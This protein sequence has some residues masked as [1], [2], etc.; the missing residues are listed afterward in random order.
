[1]V[2]LTLAGAASAMGGRLTGNGGDVVPSGYSIDSRTLRRGDLFFALVGPNH[3]GHRFAGAAADAGACALV[4]DR[5]MDLPVPVLQVADTTRGLQDLASHVRRRPDLK[6]VGITGSAGKTTAKEMTYAVVSGLSPAY[7]SQGNLNNLY[8]LPLSLL[9]MP[10]STHVAVLE[11]G[12]SYAGE[13]RRLTRIARPDVGVLLNVGRAHLQN[14]VSVQ[15]IAQAKAELFEEMGSGGTGIFNADD[16]LVRRV[17][18]RFSGFTFTFAID[19]DA[20]L[21]ATRV[22]PEGF[23]GTRFRVVHGNAGIEGRIPFLGVHHVYNALA[24][25]AVGYMLG[26]D[27]AGMMESLEQIAPLPGRGERLQL[28]GDIRL[29]DDTYNSNPAAL[30]RAIGALV[31]A[32]PAGSRRVLVTGDMLELGDHG[33][34]AHQEAGRHAAEA[35]LEVVVA[36]GPLSEQTAESAGEGGVATVVH[37]PDSE[38]AAAAVADLVRPGDTVLVKG[39]RGMRMERVVQALQVRAAGAQ[40]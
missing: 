23:A 5:E 21:R 28:P 10:A 3:D 34:A 36:V 15:E 11:M 25:L 37:L 6:V 2:E 30:R 31:A 39:S 27:L 14:F 17:A 16:E 18:D 12:M 26:G 24:A 7:R 35:R 13:L 8:G 20:D 33:P 9:R 38:E 40:G 32:A 1:M 19:R 22:T 29:I 4:A